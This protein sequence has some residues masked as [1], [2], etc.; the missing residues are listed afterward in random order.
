MGGSNITT[1]IPKA[2]KSSVSSF[3]VFLTFTRIDAS[4]R[5]QNRIL[6]SQGRSEASFRGCCTGAGNL[7]I[8]FAI[9]AAHADRAHELAVNHDRNAAGRSCNA[10]KCEKEQMSG[11]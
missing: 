1:K 5:I 3:R 6:R 11:L 9:A 7:S 2:A 10:G 4:H 8:L